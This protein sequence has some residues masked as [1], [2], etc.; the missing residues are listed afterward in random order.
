MIEALKD[1]DIFYYHGQ[2][3][4]LDEIKSDVYQVVTQPIKSLYY[5]RT[6]DS[7]GIDQYENMPNTIAQVVLIPYS[8]VSALSSRNLYV[9]DGQNSTKDRRVAISQNY[10]KVSNKEN[11]MDIKVFYIPLI[12]TKNSETETIKILN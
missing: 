6:N 11:E 5:N 9:G 4:L 3:D 10:I 12:N 2:G 7:A 1:F 8:I